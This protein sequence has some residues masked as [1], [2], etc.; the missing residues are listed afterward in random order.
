MG[1][2]NIERRKRAERFRN[3]EEGSNRN[4]TYPHITERI[5]RHDERLFDIAQREWAP[6]IAVIMESLELSGAK[7]REIVD[8]E[9]TA[10]AVKVANSPELDMRI[11]PSNMNRE[12]EFAV[13]EIKLRLLREIEKQ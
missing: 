7:K 3:R 6:G 9:L 11:D 12:E 2:S 4:P 5:S 10:T 13:N 8:R 1:L